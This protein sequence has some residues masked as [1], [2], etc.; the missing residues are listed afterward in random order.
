MR[1]KRN[2]FS[3]PAFSVTRVATGLRIRVPVKSERFRMLLNLA[4][5]LVWATGEAAIVRYLL[6]G[7]SPTGSFH[8]VSPPLAGLF[9]AAFTVAGGVVVWRCL[10]YLAGRETFLLSPDALQARR[11]IWGIG[12]SQTFPLHGIT[13]VK[14]G[15]LKYRVIYPSWG[16]RFIGHDESEIVIECGGRTHSYGRGLEDV[17]AADLVDLLK[18]ELRFHYHPQPVPEAEPASFELTEADRKAI[19]GTHG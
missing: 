16:R 3:N 11:E 14:A 8:P 12:H 2:E 19:G 15:R 1:M 5:L 4:W 6:E 9:L 10:W 18:E 17:E 7:S 13:S